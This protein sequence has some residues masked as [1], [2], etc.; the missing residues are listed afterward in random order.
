MSKQ[1]LVKFE[2]NWADEF[3]VQGFQ[4]MNQEELDSYFNAIDNYGYFMP[5][6]REIF[7]FGTN[8]SL[9]WDSKEDFLSCLTITEISEEQANT[10]KEL[11]STNYGIFP[12]IEVF[13]TIKKDCTFLDSIDI[14]NISTH[15]Y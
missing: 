6:E 15:K 10:I 1:Y 14:M 13:W 11:L 9:G 7:Y 12:D 4:I 2:D 5:G 3:D 8:Q